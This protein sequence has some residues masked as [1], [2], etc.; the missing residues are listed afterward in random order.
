MLEI[1][2]NF[3]PVGYEEIISLAGG[4][5]VHVTEAFD[6]SA[7]TGVSDVLNLFPVTAM[8]PKILTGS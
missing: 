6:G 4:K 5:A 2:E 1:R 8:F 3:S 7:K